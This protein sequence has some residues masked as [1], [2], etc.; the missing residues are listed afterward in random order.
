MVNIGQDPAVQPVLINIHYAFPTQ[1]LNNA[2]QDSIYLV[3][4]AINVRMNVLPV[5]QMHLVKVALLDITKIL[6]V[7]L[8]NTHV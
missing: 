3:L 2:T 8:V 1:N 4:L 7:N 5:H 6:I